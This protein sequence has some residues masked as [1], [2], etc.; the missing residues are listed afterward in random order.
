MNA[1][2]GAFVD[3][4][5]SRG[6]WW[7]TAV[8][9]RNW[10]LLVKLSVVLVVPVVGALV[11]GVLRVQADVA[12]AGSYAGIERIA[13]V[14]VQLVG[15]LSSIQDERNEA[16]R[17]RPD[18]KRP[19]AVTDSTLTTANGLI[20]QT[21]NLGDN[22]TQRYRNLIGA[23]DLLPYARGQVAAGADGLVVLSS[24]DAVTNAVLEFDRALVGRFPDEDLTSS[25]IALNELQ[26]AREQVSL[27]QALGLLAMRDNALSESE[28]QLMIEADVRLEDNVSDFRAVAPRPLLDRY[29]N[30]VTGPDVAQ[31]RLLVL[32]ARTPGPAP[33]FTL[34]EWNA[35]SNA[36]TALYA[37]VTGQG[38]AKLR[39]D[40]ARLADSA[41]NRAGVASVLLL[42]MVLLAAGVGGVLGRY[43]LR[44]VSLLRRTALDVA[45][46]RL[47]A[48]V[49]SIRAGAAARVA[50]DPVPL[51]TT[52]EFGQLAR[53]FDA[54]HGQAVRSAAEEAGLRSNLS[55][56]FLNLSRRSQ[57][58]VERQLRLMEQLEQKTDDPD[59]LGDLFK[60]DHL[61]TRMRRNN[62]NLMVLSGTVLGRRFT[63]PLPVA[64]VLRAAVSE[65]EHYERAVIRSAPNARIIGYAAGDLIRSVSELIENATAFSPPDSEVVITSRLLDHGAVLI[66]I[67]DLGV[68]MGEAEL[69][70]ANHRVAA[71][72]GVDVPISRQ[73]GLFV[74]GR[75][76]SRHSM[77]VRLMVRD[78]GGLCASILVPADLVVPEGAAVPPPR[79]PAVAPGSPVEPAGVAVRLE[80]AGIFVRLPVLPAASTPASI[81]FAAHTPADGEATPMP[82][83]QVPSG[84]TW[85]QR[86]AAAARHAAVAPPPVLDSVAG[87]TGLP[88]R[89]PKGQL[90]ATPVQE[91]GPAPAVRRDAAKTRGFLSNFQAGIRDGESRKGNSSP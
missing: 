26:A 17:R 1:I 80:S 69:T 52:E 40:S 46:N 25:S 9:W 86:P 63:E 51:H 43:L 76:T 78:E 71:G 27:Q 8:Q 57:G 91:P 68:G 28:R 45:T 16:M 88:K 58:L 3:S 67:L 19:A 20:R 82:A 7:S 87:P 62:E 89:V 35:T 75:L 84:F 24:Y 11:L 32:A 74:V 64:D 38:A 14:R 54:V 47:P 70:E 23:L 15:V 31:R 48:A 37:D 65:V 77:R 29:E 44:S 36:T 60:I 12:L 34:D 42:T 72:G 33:G 13:N 2:G 81:L 30:T 41:G 10:P 90:L 4:A 50:I 55:S 5:G 73:M 22:A 6:A 59:Q 66:D 61:A 39:A 21:P 49:A 56:I 83:T 79:E 85:L 18:L 53:A